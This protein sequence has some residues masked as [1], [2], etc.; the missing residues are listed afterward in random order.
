MSKYPLSILAASGAAGDAQH[1]PNFF[2]VGAPKAGTTSLYYYLDQHPEVFMCPVKEANHFASEIRPEGFAEHLQGRVRREIK[3]TRKYLAG[4]MSEKRFGA[5][6]L[7]WDE[8][9]RLFR[10]VKREKA[11]GEASV[12][13]LWSQTAAQNIAA[14]IPAAKIVMILRDPVERAFSQY[15]Q[16]ASQG[17]VGESFLEVCHKSIANTGGKFQ[18]MSPFLEMGLYAEQV[19]RYLDLF[20]R[21]NILIYLYEDYVRD[22]EGVLKETFRFLDV[23]AAFRP[24]LST[25]HLVP[26]GHRRVMDNRDKSSLREFYREDV[27]KL[28]TILGRDLYGWIT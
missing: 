19:K 10:N 28:S 24:D 21:Q 8:Y 23:N 1:I 18:W 15:M 6:G 9:L 25:R 12:C 2:I 17:E 5:I 11:I 14:R 3:A 16:W 27:Q 26:K 22:P 4:P 20:P 13:Y 7:E